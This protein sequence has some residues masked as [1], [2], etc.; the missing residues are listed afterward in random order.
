MRYC[1]TLNR[2]K[3]ICRASD[4]TQYSLAYTELDIQVLSDLVIR[5]S[6]QI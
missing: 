4:L 1:L 6:Y 5:F 2:T 3:R